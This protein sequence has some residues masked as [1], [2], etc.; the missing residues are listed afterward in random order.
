MVRSFAGEMR[1]RPIAFPLFVFPDADRVSE[2]G[3]AGGFRAASRA[4]RAAQWLCSE[5]GEGREQRA[6][7]GRAGA[8]ITVLAG[9][10]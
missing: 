8:G 3:I 1:G 9:G 5:A 6:P 2:Q 10:W 4:I 7:E